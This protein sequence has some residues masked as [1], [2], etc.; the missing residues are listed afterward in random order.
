MSNGADQAVIVA[1][2]NGAQTP[3]I[4]KFAKYLRQITLYQWIETRGWYTRASLQ[5]HR[6]PTGKTVLVWGGSSSV[7]CNAIQL[8]VAAGLP[9]FAPRAGHLVHIVASAIL[10]D[11]LGDEVENQL[12][13]SGRVH[14][15][16]EHTLGGTRPVR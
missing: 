12:A 8:A 1:Y 16:G 9:S 10:T 15:R 7:G 13:G 2:E 3:L 5:V 4:Y 6:K 11:G 14:T